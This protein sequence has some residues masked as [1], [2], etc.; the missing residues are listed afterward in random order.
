MK[1]LPYFLAIVIAV[2]SSCSNQADK[3]PNRPKVTPAPKQESAEGSLRQARNYG[4]EADKK[5]AEARA[6]LVEAKTGLENYR[7]RVS[8][9]QDIVRKLRDNGQAGL[10]ELQKLYEELDKQEG[11]IVALSENLESVEQDLQV[12]RELRLKASLELSEATAKALRKEA[13][14]DQLRQQLADS[15]LTIDTYEASAQA[16]HKAAMDAMGAADRV[17]GEKRLIVKILIAVSALAALSLVANYLQLK[18]I[19]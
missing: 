3:V 7:T 4:S 14:A 2:L 8:N 18:G 13:E 10:D 15:E 17:K 16:N 6:K 12:E 19:F 11:L 5:G 9:L 1:I